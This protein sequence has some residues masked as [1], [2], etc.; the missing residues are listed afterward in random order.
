MLT[1][2]PKQILAYPG[3]VGLA[4]YSG[5]PA[6]RRGR[7]VVMRFPMACLR[8][9]SGAGGLAERQ[10]HPIFTEKCSV[11]APR[12]HYSTLSNRKLAGR[13]GSFLPH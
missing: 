2:V 10:V 11:P 6:Q 4:D 7:E 12:L 9:R 5:L 13:F 8:N 1:E 3:V